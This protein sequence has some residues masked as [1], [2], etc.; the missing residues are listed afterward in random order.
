[1][2]LIAALIAHIAGYPPKGT[3]PRP[4]CAAW[5]YHDDLDLAIAKIARPECRQE[6]HGT[7]PSL[8]PISSAPHEQ[9]RPCIRTTGLQL[10]QCPGQRAG[11]GNALRASSFRLQDVYDGRPLSIYIVIP[12]EKLES[13]KALLRLW[14]GTLLTAGHAP[15][16]HAAAANAVPSRRVRPARLADHACGRRLRC[17]AAAACRP[18]R[19]GRI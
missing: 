15:H 13:H 8:S 19:S 16:D 17:C 7:G 4:V 3:A 5:L 11:G 10:R 18:G 2:V 9:T 14:V 6:P 12:P 1:M